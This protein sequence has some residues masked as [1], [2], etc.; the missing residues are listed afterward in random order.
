VAS[1]SRADGDVIGG[2]VLELDERD[3]PWGVCSCFIADDWQKETNSF[4]HGE[5]IEG[6]MFILMSDIG[7]LLKPNGSPPV[8]GVIPTV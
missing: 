8:T 2:V 6:D 7:V 5:K 1:I 3:G 4:W